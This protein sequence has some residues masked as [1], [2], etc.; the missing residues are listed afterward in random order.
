M[1]VYDTICPIY[2]I[3]SIYSLFKSMWDSYTNIQILSDEKILLDNF[4]DWNIY[5][6]TSDKHILD[7]KDCSF[8]IYQ[9][10]EIVE[11]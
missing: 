4:P 6:V 8:E 10:E 1:E 11:D 5:L 3:T 7:E 2:F 9:I